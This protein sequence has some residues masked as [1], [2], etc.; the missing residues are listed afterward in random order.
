MLTP[1]P[2]KNR[3]EGFHSA[4]TPNFRA[5]QFNVLGQTTRPEV[6]LVA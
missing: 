6:G 2:R 5:S 1:E 4:Q 3:L